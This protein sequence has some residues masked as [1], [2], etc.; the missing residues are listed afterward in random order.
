MFKG[1]LE[2]SEVDLHSTADE[3]WDLCKRVSPTKEVRGVLDPGFIESNIFGNEEFS[4]FVVT[5]VYH[6]HEIV[7]H[8]RTLELPQKYLA[9]NL[10]AGWGMDTRNLIEAERKVGK[11]VAVVDLEL[12]PTISA[13]DNIVNSKNGLSSQTYCVIGDLVS[14]PFPP[15]RVD[16][17][18]SSGVLRYQ[19]SSEDSVNPANLEKNL[20]D[21]LSIVKPSGYTVHMEIGD[22]AERFFRGDGQGGFNKVLNKEGYQE[23]PADSKNLKPGEFTITEV[24]IPNLVRFTRWYLLYALTS[25]EG[26]LIIPKDISESDR[27]SLEELIQRLKSRLKS[28]FP[29]DKKDPD[30]AEKNSALLRELLD[31][32][33]TEDKKALIL[34]ARKP[35]KQPVKLD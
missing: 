33:G 22:A 30:Y 11:K 23:K 13:F 3:I 28:E 1:T 32:A 2:A 26:N 9:V 12:E 4:K 8:I 25:G 14:T 5:E 31:L 21:S 35:N 15:N 19:I 18:L 29:L 16:L 27:T 20:K 6:P 24:T 7:D 34:T 10:G 17:V